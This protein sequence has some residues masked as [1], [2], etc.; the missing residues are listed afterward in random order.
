MKSTHRSCSIATGFVPPAAAFGKLPF[1]Q[2]QSFIDTSMIIQ[3]RSDGPPSPPTRKLSKSIRTES[4]QSIT[5]IFLDE[6]RFDE[7]LPR[8]PISDD[9]CSAT[10]TLTTITTTCN[11]QNAVNKPLSSHQKYVRFQ[12]DED[13]DIDEE[14]SLKSFSKYQLTQQDM[15]L[16]WWS[17]EQR[18]QLKT[19][20]PN[21]CKEICKQLPLYRRALHKLCTLASRKEYADLLDS[22]SALESLESLADAR[23]RGLE[24]PMLYKYAL[25]RRSSKSYTQLLLK[26]QQM[27]RDMFDDEY[28][29]EEKAQVLA[30]QYR[31]NARPSVRFAEILA[32]ADAL[33]VRW[34]LEEILET[35]ATTSSLSL[36]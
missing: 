11:E 9:E 8:V 27:L 31:I 13:G 33:A 1:P 24:R 25:P 12:L 36:S 23:V 20:I 10:E 28:T 19:S 7:H 2:Q 6:Q 34:E 35:K 17:K 29:A 26:T 3:N 30:D 18:R 32:I 22:D 21:Q 15:T 14:I 5:A 16:L 4:P